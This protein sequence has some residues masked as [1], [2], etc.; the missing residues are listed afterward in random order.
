M[1]TST[2]GAPPSFENVSAEAAAAGAAAPDP[3]EVPPTPTFGAGGESQASEHGSVPG[4]HAGTDDRRVNDD[5]HS[6]E[7]DQQCG[8]GR[9]TRLTEWT[10]ES[11]AAAMGLDGGGHWQRATTDGDHR[12]WSATTAPSTTGRARDPWA[13][14][15]PWQ[16]D[17]RDGGGAGEQWHYWG[18]DRDQRQRRTSSITRPRRVSRRSL[19]RWPR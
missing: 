5:E 16:A 15:D 10:G 4:P 6:A 7:R 17:F 11:S 19:G 3:S 9:P 13:D 14:N 12:S 18:D 8:A 2:V 1:S